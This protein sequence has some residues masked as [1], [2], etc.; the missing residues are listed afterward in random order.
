MKVVRDN[1]YRS[2]WGKDVSGG[3]ASDILGP[4]KEE[5]GDTLSAAGYQTLAQT[6]RFKNIMLHETT[7]LER[8]NALQSTQT[9]GP[10]APSIRVIGQGEMVIDEQGSAFYQINPTS[11]RSLRNGRRQVPSIRLPLGQSAPPVERTAGQ[12]TPALSQTMNNNIGSQTTR[13]RAPHRINTMNTNSTRAFIKPHSARPAALPVRRKGGKRQPPINKPHRVYP[14]PFMNAPARSD[15]AAANTPETS[16]QATLSGATE[17]AARQGNIDKIQDY[18]FRATACKRA[19]RRRAEANA[20]YSMGVLYDNNRDFLKAIQCYQAFQQV[21]VSSEDKFAQALA[22]NSIGVALMNLGGDYLKQ[23]IHYHEQHR[24]LADVPGKFIA[25]TNL[26]LVYQLLSD[27]QQAAVNHQHAL[28]CAIR[29]SS[30]A[31]QSV[32]IGNL[33][34]TGLANGDLNSARVCIERH[35]E[36]SRQLDDPA[37]ES[38]ALKILGEIANA[39]GNF[40]DAA[41]NFSEAWRTAANSGNNQLANISKVNIGVARATVTMADKM[42]EMGERMA[43]AR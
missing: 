23:S 4:A 41:D 2:N 35:V 7:P 28:R 36:L 22:F 30:V 37:A 25:F 1:A 13:E 26:G 38:S 17:N 42:R 11:T 40:E 8:A 12:P 29:M 27:N 21:L 10:S 6:P 20:Y 14:P 15:F 18:V 32:A 3:Q 19:G 16:P 34:L 39:Q 9:S 33:G 43:A 24:E 5:K 31:G